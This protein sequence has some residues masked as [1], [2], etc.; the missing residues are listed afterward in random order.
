VGYLKMKFTKRSKY[1]TAKD[2]LLRMVLRG[3][4]AKY[5][6]EL[7]IPEGTTAEVRRKP[8]TWGKKYGHIDS[9]LL[10][11]PTLEYKQRRGLMESYV[12]DATEQTVG[13][14]YKKLVKH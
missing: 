12:F 7:Y 13:I 9:V 6:D 11:T 10:S 8:M 1:L 3:L 5:L 2:G 4:Y 14:E